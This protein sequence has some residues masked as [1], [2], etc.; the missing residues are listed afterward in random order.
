MKLQIRPFRE[1]DLQPLYELLSD[2]EVMRWIEPP[3]TLDQTKAFLEKAGLCDPPLIYAVDEEDSGFIGYV[4][5]HDYEAGSLE[6]GWILKRNVWGKG[7]AGTLTAQLVEKAKA[8]GRSVI[9]EC[10]P[11]Q[12]VTKHIAEKYGFSYIGRR[13]GCDVYELKTEQHPALKVVIPK[14]EELWFRQKMLA[15]PETMSYNHAWGG[16]ISFP[17]SAWEGWYRHWVT[18]HRGKRWYRY[19]KNGKGNFIGEIAYHFDE[20][21]RIHLADV[22]VYSP[23][24]GKG[25]GSRALDM[26][27]GAARKNGVRFLYDDIAIDN[28]AISL[29]LKQGFTEEYR[30]DEIIMLK[31]EL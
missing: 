24:R 31:K 13:E 15:D 4:I 30:T 25:Y 11:E 10:D 14:Y 3:F 21:S 9:I 20:K 6:I 1:D 8:A 17:E 16:T 7:Y 5:C 29:F 19:L 18:D 2:A 27:C 12:S 23:Y 22:I 26:L 28:P